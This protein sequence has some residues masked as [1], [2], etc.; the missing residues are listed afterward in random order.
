MATPARPRS[1]PNQGLENCHGANVSSAPDKIDIGLGAINEIAV[2][3]VEAGF[4]AAGHA[5]RLG[6]IVADLAPFI[7][8]RGAEI[9][10]GPAIG[11]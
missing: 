8:E 10:A 6:R 1:V 3:P 2:L 9:G 4:E 7:A 5:G 11:E